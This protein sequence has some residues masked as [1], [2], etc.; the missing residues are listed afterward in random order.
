M[1]G[2]QRS[3][4]TGQL[5]IEDEMK[6]AYMTFAMSVI[7]ARALPDVRDGLKPCQRRILTAMNELNLGPESKTRKCGKIVGDTGGNYHPHGDQAI[8]DAL[9]RMGRPFSF[10]YPLVRGQGNF[11]SMDGDPPAAMRYT[12]ARL[13]AVGAQM[14]QDIRLDTV[15]MVDNYDNTRQEPSVLPGRF[16]NLLANG[17]SGIAVGMATS[18]P[19]HN[20]AELCD[21]IIAVIAEPDITIEGIMEVLPGPDFPTGGIIRGRGGIR[22]AYATGRGQLTL[23]ARTVFE[24]G[25]GGQRRIVVTEVPFHMSRDSVVERIADSVQSGKVDGISDI[26]NESDKDGTRLVIDLKRGADEEVVLNNLFRHTPLRTTE[27]II[28]LAVDGGRPRTF[29]I[30][31][32][33]Q[34]YIDHRVN[35]IIRRT[36]HLL[37]RAEQRAHVLE[38]LRTALIN[39]DEVLRLIRGCEDEETARTGLMDRFDL[40]ETQANAILA[41][42][43]RTLVGLERLKID[44]EY[45]QLQEKITDYNQTLADRNLILDIIREDLYEMKERFGDERRTTIAEE[46]EDLMDEDLIREH[47][48]VVTLS[49]D[50]YVKRVPTGT[51]RQQGRGGKGVIGADL[52]EEDFVKDLFVASTHDYIMLFTNFGLVYWLRV[53]EIPEMRRTTKGRAL[54]NLLPIRD[55]ERVTGLIPVTEFEQEHYLLMATAHGKVKKTSLDA[56]GKRGAGG[57]IALDLRENDRLIGVVKTDG[58]HD[59][60]LA[61]RNGRA[62]RFHESDVRAMGRTAA[63]VRGIRLAKGDR[64]VSLAPVKDGSKLLSVCENG[65]G[66]RTEFCEYP[67]RHR[68]GQGVI[69]IKTTAR[70]GRVVGAVGVPDGGVIM[71][72]T[73]GGMMVKIPADQVRCISRNTQGV[74]LIAMEEGDKVSA[75]VGLE[76]ESGDDESA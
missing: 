47:D 33:M 13:S 41:M 1:D 50:D 6:D 28:L 36:S 3:G 52:K 51:F 53:F 34:S 55:G 58:E 59:V 9:V 24:E 42:R 14:L 56:F 62:I 74:R 54:I 43:I 35:V 44:R 40:S 25:K 71:I 76:E 37:K 17:A 49:R 19:P 66:K 18:I 31:E 61:T 15:D 10:R 32:C 60:I 30:R 20:T 16:P 57:I 4:H 22:R 68:G 73:E 45:D 2:P 7:V 46:A 75:V 39:I 11:G 21:A 5:L 67:A 64:V 48:V 26:R 63:G 12:E 29:N 65:Y 69:D 72:A 23:Q 8:Y 27:S 38:G 70:N